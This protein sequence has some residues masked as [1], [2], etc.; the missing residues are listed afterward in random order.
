VAPQQHPCP[1]LPLVTVRVTAHYCGYHQAWS[2][3][4]ELIRQDANEPEEV[5]TGELELGPFDD[6]LDLLEL[7]RSKFEAMVHAAPSLAGF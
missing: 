6:T 3:R 7:A 1:N 2:A 5:V 4:W